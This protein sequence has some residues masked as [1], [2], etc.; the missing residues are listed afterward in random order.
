MYKYL[1]KEVDIIFH[2]KFSDERLHTH[3]F[4]QN[5]LNS[6]YAILDCCID[7]RGAYFEDNLNS[8]SLQQQKKL[9]NLIH[10][11]LTGTY[12]NF[13]YLISQKCISRK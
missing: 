12:S 13:C 2:I 5:Q 11:V 7:H 8:N 3:L 9:I 4:F 6:L 10:A 1:Q